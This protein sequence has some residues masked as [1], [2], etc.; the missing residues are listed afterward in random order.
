MMGG[1]TASGAG[2][3]AVTTGYPPSP[4]DAMTAPPGKR[5]RLATTRGSLHSGIPVAL[6]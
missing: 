6:T 5:L 4:R 1:A 3:A 2:A